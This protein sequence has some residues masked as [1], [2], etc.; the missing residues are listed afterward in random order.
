[1][2]GYKGVVL[3]N[4]ILRSKYGDIFEV[5]IPRE[6]QEV[7]DGVAFTECG[8]SFCETIEEVVCHEN[9]IMS[10]EHRRIRDVRLFE[11]DTL[12]EKVIGK[13]Y[14]YKASRIKLVREVSKNE[15][16]KYFEDNILAKQR[17]IR[18]LKKEKNV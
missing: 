6:Y 8:Y 2:I 12:D 5:D 4:G 13:S 17:L 15:I 1:M 10:L 9:F 14:H 18:Q 3:K 16:I 11:V 7:D